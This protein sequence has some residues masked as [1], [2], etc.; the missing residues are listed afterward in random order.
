MTKDLN[1]ERR[2]LAD[3]KNKIK[4]P[5]ARGF[6]GFDFS[7]NLR[8]NAVSVFVITASLVFWLIYQFR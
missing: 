1:R 4:P 7:I 5:K 8:G 3:S 6:R 2:Y